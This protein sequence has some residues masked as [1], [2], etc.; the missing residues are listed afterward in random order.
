MKGAPFLSNKAGFI[1]TQGGGPFFG[2]NI[3][4]IIALFNLGGLFYGSR[5]TGTQ[6]FCKLREAHLNLKIL[7]EYCAVVKCETIR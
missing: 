7:N 6:C 4:E 2:F 5:I 3:G 1:F